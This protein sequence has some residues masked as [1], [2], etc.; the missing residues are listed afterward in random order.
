MNLL[1]NRFYRFIQHPL[2]LINIAIKVIDSSWT[3]PR[4]RNIIK[5]MWPQ[6]TK[7]RINS[8][9]RD[10][11]VKYHLKHGLEMGGG[12]HAQPYQVSVQ[13]KEHCF[14]IVALEFIFEFGKSRLG[15]DVRETHNGEKQNHKKMDHICKLKRNNNN[16]E[17]WALANTNIVIEMIQYQTVV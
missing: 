9:I 14:P 10:L 6:I 12:L 17:K 16:T 2:P 5:I 1:K 3:P 13:T 4:D 11:V 15:G 7:D 8:P